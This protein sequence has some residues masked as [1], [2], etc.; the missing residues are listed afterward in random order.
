MHKT[1]RNI[2]LFVYLFIY[3]L[4]VSFLKFFLPRVIYFHQVC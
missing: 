3:L 2:Y 1:L 4:E